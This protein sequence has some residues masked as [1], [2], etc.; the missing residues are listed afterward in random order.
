M[1]TLRIHLEDRVPALRCRHRA[2][3]ITVGRDLFG[4]WIA[5]M[6]YGRIGTAGTAVAHRRDVLP[7]F[8]HLATYLNGHRPARDSGRMCAE[9]SSWGASKAGSILPV[10]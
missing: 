2:Y 8:G 1:S 6:T 3:E 9:T 7:G 10:S 4:I 5:E